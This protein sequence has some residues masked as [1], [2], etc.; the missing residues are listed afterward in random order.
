M[1][2][3]KNDQREKDHNQEAHI[4]FSQSIILW[5]WYKKYIYLYIQ[6]FIHKNWCMS[7]FPLSN[8]LTKYKTI[9][10]IYK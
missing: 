1:L 7:L 10:K 2:F 4:Y 5:S 9:V 3:K 6:R 8:N